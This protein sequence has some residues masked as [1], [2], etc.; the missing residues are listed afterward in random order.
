MTYMEFFHQDARR[1]IWAL[2][3]AT[4]I[5]Q[6]RLLLNGLI[7]GWKRVTRRSASV[8]LITMKMIAVRRA[9]FATP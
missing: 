7:D 9:F 3:G 4:R 6:R 5:R 8:F 1:S 2:I